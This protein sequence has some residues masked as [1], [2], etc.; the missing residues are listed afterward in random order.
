MA[1]TFHRLTAAVIT[2]ASAGL[3][4]TAN[5]QWIG[6]NLHTAGATESYAC[7]GDSGQQVGAAR[8]GGQLHAG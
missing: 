8:I 7:G 5:G 3:A 6:T 4:A 2:C 1:A